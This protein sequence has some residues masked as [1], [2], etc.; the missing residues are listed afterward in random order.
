MGGYMSVGKSVWNL[1]LT[2]MSYPEKLQECSPRISVQWLHW[3]LNQCPLSEVSYRYKLYRFQNQQVGENRR[4][5]Y[6]Q[7]SSDLFIESMLYIPVAL[8]SYELDS[9]FP[10]ELVVLPKWD[11][12]WVK[13]SLP[14]GILMILYQEGKKKSLYQWRESCLV[15]MRC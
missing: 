10:K 6:Y 2:F 8:G 7:L 3:K 13:Q 15:I 1:C 5:F 9:Q 4:D 14:H 12:I 11:R